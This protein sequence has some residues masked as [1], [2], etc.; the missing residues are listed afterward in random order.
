VLDGVAGATKSTASVIESATREVG[1]LQRRLTDLPNT[2][3]RTLM[4][5]I[6]RQYD[7]DAK[8]S[9]GKEGGKGVQGTARVGGGVGGS[10]ARRGGGRRESR[11]GKSSP[12][13]ARARGGSTARPGAGSRSRGGISSGSGSTARCRGRI[14]RTHG[15][16]SS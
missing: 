5:A 9:G 12:A 14:T 7:G 1:V 8:A 11:S 13:N 16:S 4:E 2:A 10:W 15:E 3:S 6:T